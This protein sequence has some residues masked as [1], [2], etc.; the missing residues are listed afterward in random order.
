MALVVEDGQQETMNINMQQPTTG[1]S[2]YLLI[3]KKMHE[4]FARH[5]WVKGASWHVPPPLLITNHY[6]ST[7]ATME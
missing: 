5:K 6:I 7:L 1:K 4:P 3:D 2:H